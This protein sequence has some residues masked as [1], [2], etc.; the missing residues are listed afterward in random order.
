MINV[1]FKKERVENRR[2]E[3]SVEIRWWFNEG[4]KYLP[5]VYAIKECYSW[6]IYD[7]DGECYTNGLGYYGA[8]RSKEDAKAYI[9]NYDKEEDARLKGIEEEEAKRFAEWEERKALENEYLEA[10]IAPSKGKDVK[11]DDIIKVVSC[12]ASKVSDIGEALKY[13]NENSYV[14]NAKIVKVIEVND[15]EYERFAKRTLCNDDIFEYY[16]NEDGSF[17]GGSYSDDPAFDDIPDGE[18]YKIM[19]N[20]KLREIFNNTRVEVLNAIVCEGRNNIY[21]N[22]EGY[23]YARYLAFDVEVVNNIFYK[24]ELVA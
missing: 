9:E 23:G 24:K 8:L 1:K 22:T 10:Y 21:V 14:V 6:E 15:E 13:I 2:Y 20:P 11:A 7:A 5:P 17:A 4:T 19:N 12:G 16:K 3:G 18:F